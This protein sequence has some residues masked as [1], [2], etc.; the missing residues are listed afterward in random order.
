MTYKPDQYRA[1]KTKLMALNGAIADL[2]EP[3]SM[4]AIRSQLKTHVQIQNFFHNEI[5]ESSASG[6]SSDNG[7]RAEAQQQQ[8]SEEVL[9]RQ[10]VEINKQL[11]LLGADL[12]LLVAARNP[13]T[14]AQR[15]KQAGDRLN[16][17]ISM[18]D[19]LLQI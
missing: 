5:L 14:F 11:R 7:D 4:P 16:I 8:I 9:V 13:A 12:N 6:D 17:L 1:L 2:S 15:Q 10:Y 18:C 3:Q 19:A